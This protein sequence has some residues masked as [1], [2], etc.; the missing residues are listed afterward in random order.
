MVLPLPNP[1]RIPTPNKNRQ[2]HLKHQ[3]Q[4]PKV[5]NETI[6]KNERATPTKPNNIIKSQE[7]EHP[8]PLWADKQQEYGKSS[9]G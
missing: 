5:H 2:L 9:R 8:N 1:N 4:D 3:Q 6:L 7:K